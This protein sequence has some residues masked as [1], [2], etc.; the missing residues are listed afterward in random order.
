MLKILMLIVLIGF[1][2]R[3]FVPSAKQIS[4]QADPEPDEFIDYEEIKEDGENK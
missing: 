4:G 2:Y 3:L 1:A